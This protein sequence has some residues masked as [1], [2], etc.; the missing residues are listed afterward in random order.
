MPEISEPTTDPVDTTFTSTGPARCRPGACRGG[1]FDSAPAASPDAGAQRIGELLG[2]LDAGVHVVE[3]T[4]E[5]GIG[6]SRLLAEIARLAGA[7]EIRVF[8]GAAPPDGALFPFDAFVDVADRRRGDRD[9]SRIATRRPGDVDLGRAPL[10]GVPPEHRAV[11]RD[12]LPPTAGPTGSRARPGRPLQAYQRF[13]AVYALLEPYLS[14]GG[15]L[16]VVLDVPPAHPPRPLGPEAV[17]DPASEAAREPGADEAAP[18]RADPPVVVR[19]RPG[20]RRTGR[21]APTV[22]TNRERQ[23]AELA[24]DGL[25]NREIAAALFVTEKTVEMH[26]THVFAK[27]DVRNRVGLARRLHAAGRSE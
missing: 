21:P 13:D 7:R 12:L 1:G 19:S 26:L 17:A 10:P 16:V 24:G 9:R 8:S 2:D 25:T 23:V 11:L 14:A 6:K 3:V 27:L 15:P 18:E 20:R 5:A 22:L 4:A